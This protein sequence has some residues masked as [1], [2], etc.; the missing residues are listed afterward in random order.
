MLVSFTPDG[1][2]FVFHEDT[3]A[4]IAKGFKSRRLAETWVSRELGFAPQR[5][6]AR[7]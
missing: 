6:R 5:P 7:E 1:S 2:W 4:T 3:G